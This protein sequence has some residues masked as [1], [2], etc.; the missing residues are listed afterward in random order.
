MDT[1]LVNYK[2][3]AEMI[4]LPL[5]TL[6]ALV[7]QKRIPHVRLGKRLVMFSIPEIMAWIVEHKVDVNSKQE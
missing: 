7:S 4:G 1:N 5:G 6:Y 2:Q 3:A